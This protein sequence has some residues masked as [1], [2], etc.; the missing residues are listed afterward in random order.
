MCLRNISMVP[1]RCQWKLCWRMVR[2]GHLP[3]QPTERVRNLWSY[4]PILLYFEILSYLFVTSIS[5]K[6][7]SSWFNKKLLY[8]I[9]VPSI[10]KRQ[11]Y[12]S[13]LLLCRCVKI[14]L[15]L[16]GLSNE[17]SSIIW[18]LDWIYAVLKWQKRQLLNLAPLYESMGII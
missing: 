14:S 16:N 9:S 2:G 15:D 11:V 18:N 6:N 3:F 5:K 4:I 1:K 7:S 12:R 10:K 17:K 8:K 13:S